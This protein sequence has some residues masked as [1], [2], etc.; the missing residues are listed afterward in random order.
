MKAD[1]ITLVPTEDGKRWGVEAEGADVE[2][3]AR[4]G[5]SIRPA[6][7][8]DGEAVYRISI[9]GED[10]EGHRVHVAGLKRGHCAGHERHPRPRYTS[11]FS[12]GGASMK[13]DKIT[14]VPTED[15]KHWRVEAEGGDVEGHARQ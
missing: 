1:K 11:K 3:H 10:V 4:R 7:E 14:L 13:A 8:Q 12:E 5:F 2:G 6:G 9:D 15:G